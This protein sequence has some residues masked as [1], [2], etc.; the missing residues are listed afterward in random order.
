MEVLNDFNGLTT[1]N[2]KDIS[3][4]HAATQEYLVFSTA[5]N[6]LKSIGFDISF[7]LLKR[8]LDERKINAYAWLADGY[9]RIDTFPVPSS[10][11]DS[12]INSDDLMLTVAPSFIKADIYRFYFI[13]KSGG[14]IKKDGIGINI[15]IDIRVAESIVS[16]SVMGVSYFAKWAPLEGDIIRLP[17][18]KVSELNELAKDA[19]R[20][21]REI[22]NMRSGV[23][24]S[25]PNDLSERL[26]QLE[27]EN[28][29]LKQQLGNA[30]SNSTFIA[31]GALVELLTEQKTPR[32]TQSR[33]KDELEDKALKGL[34]RGSLN[35]IFAAANKALKA[36][37]DAG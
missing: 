10:E 16:D 5:I 9:D 30:P 12:L 15:F 25:S 19:A 13:E 28:E 18:L 27:R 4:Q 24:Q 6:Y 21:T 14:A 33:I 23:I 11:M 8:Y 26:K 7:Q 37:K 20:T 1:S 31:V 34:S 29:L 35:D 36:S 3:P 32:R 2:T 22:E 17:F